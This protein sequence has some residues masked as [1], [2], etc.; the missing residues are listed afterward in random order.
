MAAYR[1]DAADLTYTQLNQIIRAKVAE[2]TKEI[3]IENVLGQ[4]FIADG[5]KG[6]V[7]IT[8]HGVP[9]GTWGCS[10]QARPASSTGTPSTRRGTP[11]T[12]G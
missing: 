8:I 5:L 12:R 11:W 9:G 10:C 3:E 7:R 1:I 6:D 4:R 2:G